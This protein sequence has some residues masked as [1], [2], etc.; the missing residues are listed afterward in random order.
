[1]ELAGRVDAAIEAALGSRIVGC[2]VLVN[3]DGST[4]YATAQG[5]AD[6]EA[7][8]AM[9]R[10]A[11]FRLASVTK[12]IVAT[13]ALRMID[14]GL[15]GLDDPVTKVLPWFTPSAP[16]G[17]RPTITI[18]QLMTHSS[19]ITYDV[20]KDVAPGLVGP[21]V[22]LEENLRRFAKAPL[23]FAPGTAWA[24]GMSI[25]V[26]GGVIATINGASLD[27][28]IG[29][30][31]AGR[32]AWSTRIFASPTKNGLPSP[33]PTG[34]HRAGWESRRRWSDDRRRRHELFSRPHLQRQCAA[35]RRRRHRGNRRR[36]HEDARHL[37]RRRADPEAG[38]D[39]RGPEEPDRRFAQGRERRRQAL[40]PDRRIDRRPRERRARPAQLGPW[41]GAAPGATIGSSIPSI[42]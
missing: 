25:D 27:E 33:M 6:R 1:M 39:R 11:I 17:T 35:I 31:S 22:S 14:L 18:R 13:T 30:M 28:T 12:P 34:G 41:I 10:D 3:K 9:T 8:R 42:G 40:Q 4:V 23:A 16:D 36:H 20:P 19:G 32:L 37:Q 24:Y 38:D 15:L 7:G 29:N 2:V 21:I 26:L 5:L